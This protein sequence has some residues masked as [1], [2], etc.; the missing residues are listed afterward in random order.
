MPS[1]QTKAIEAKV[2]EILK[3]SS[4]EYKAKFVPQSQS[5]NRDQKERTLN[6][7]VT[8]TKGRMS[9]STDY[10]QGI[11]HMPGYQQWTKTNYERMQR[12]ALAKYASEHGKTGQCMRDSTIISPR[13]P[14]PPPTAADVLH[15]LL[16][17][18]AVLD[19]GGFESWACE[20]GYD[21]DSRKAEATY[22]ACVEIA[23]K[24]RGIFSD[25]ERAQLSEA[26]QDY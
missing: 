14:L 8:L 21:T 24:M 15:S 9:F 18:S 6:W 5:R 11:A 26:L 10:M 12:D 2:T 17:E 4:V 19:S 13:S 3:A 7:V 20:Y 22:K 1:E 25:A 23:L 16:L